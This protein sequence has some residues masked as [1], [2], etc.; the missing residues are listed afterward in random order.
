M[1]IRN[2]KV[3]LIVHAYVLAPNGAK[4]SEG[5]AVIEQPWWFRLGFST[6]RDAYI[7]VTS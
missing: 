1:N 3:V 7:T 2:P 6:Y 5:T 4:P